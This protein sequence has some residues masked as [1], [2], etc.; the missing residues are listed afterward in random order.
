MT[1]TRTPLAAARPRD[2]RLVLV[3]LAAGALVLAVGLAVVGL[4]DTAAFFRTPSELAERPVEVGRSVR[5]GGLVAPGSLTARD[6]ALVFQLVDDISGLEIAY[7]GPVPSL[8]REGQCVIAEGVWTGAEPL[9]ARRL[10]AKH[11][12][13]YNPPELAEANRLARSCAG[14]MSGEARA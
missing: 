3:L 4:R 8:F 6:D 9:Q 12:E 11:D 5:I 2:R 10:L 1:A 13:E 14:D 7:I